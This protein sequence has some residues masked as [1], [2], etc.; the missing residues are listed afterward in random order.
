MPAYPTGIDV[1]QSSSQFQPQQWDASAAQPQLTEEPTGP[2]I[3]LDEL[4]RKG[5]A[6]TPSGGAAG[7]ADMGPSS[8]V[9][10][11]ASE[12]TT[13]GGVEPGGTMPPNAPHGGASNL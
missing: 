13:A 11:A 1:S 2:G 4:I 3:A 8:A 6:A 9:L 12:G 7:A 10:K 5:Q